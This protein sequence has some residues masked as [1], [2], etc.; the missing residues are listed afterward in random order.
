MQSPT[1]KPI[2]RWPRR[3]GVALC[4]LLIATSLPSDVL[5]ESTVPGMSET[6][7]AKECKRLRDSYDYLMNY[8]REKPRTRSKF[9]AAAAN[10]KLQA[11]SL[12]CDWVASPQ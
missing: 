10:V 2:R 7:K 6:Q 12:E 11:E 9:K 4:S 1:Q 5:S 8:Y 3:L